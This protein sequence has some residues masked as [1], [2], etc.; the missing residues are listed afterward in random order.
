MSTQEIYHYIKVDDRLITGGQPTEEQ[1][2]SAAAEGIRTV[3]NLAPLNP[4]NSLKDEAGLVQSLG[5]AYY[6]IP[7]DWEHPTESDFETFEG[8]VKQLTEGR[9]L[10]HCAANFRVTAF[11]SLYALKHLS[12]SKRK[13]TRFGLPFGK[14][15]ITRCGKNSSAR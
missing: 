7:V 13:Q 12:R 8:V 3:I 5:M 6:H 15:V 2:K 11:Y 4:H 10:I 1:L 9:T 14:T